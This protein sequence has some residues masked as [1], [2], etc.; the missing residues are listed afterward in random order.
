M[1]QDNSWTRLGPVF[2]HPPY[3]VMGAASVLVLIA[4]GIG[5]AV[6]FHGRHLQ[7][8]HLRGLG[9]LL[10]TG[11]WIAPIVGVLTLIGWQAARHFRELPLEQVPMA[12]YNPGSDAA[13]GLSISGPQ[14]LK[15]RE[16][17]TDEPNWVRQP[18]SVTPL[19]TLLVLS[20]ERFATLEEAERQVT[21]QALE[22]IR[23]HFHEEFPN[24][25]KWNIPVSVIEQQAVKR[26]AYEVMDKDFGGG[27]KS[28]MYRAHLQL[29]FSPELRQALFGTWHAG[30][31]QHR[32][33]VLG[34]LFALVTLILGTIASYI[35][36]DDLSFG[37]YS[38]RLKFAA[39]ALIAA[40]S[41][42]AAQF[43][44]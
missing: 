39:G 4:L 8:R 21:G 20:S 10:L 33:L 14:F 38:G 35:R 30:V 13:E 1:L 42:I 44:Q 41:L 34:S 23:R 29:H 6:W 36:L 24:Y 31:V 16:M 28:K 3:V 15:A 17:T 40:G 26:S 5:V 18:V 11:I 32:L 43:V 2:S 19:G 37:I 12:E 9:V 22:A 27:F 7:A 25:G